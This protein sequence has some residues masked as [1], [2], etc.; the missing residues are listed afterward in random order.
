[1]NRRDYYFKQRVM[2]DELDAG[3]TGAEAAD[4]DLAVDSG[5]VGVMYGLN[6]AQ[7][8]VP[9]LTVLV[10]QGTAYDSQGQR[11]HVDNEQSV[12]CSIDHLGVNTAVVNA[13][14]RKIVSIF[15]EFERSLSDPRTDGNGANVYFQRDEGFI[16]WVKQGAESNYPP[17]PTPPTLESGAILLCDITL[18]FGQATIQ[19]ADISMARTQLQ[20]MLNGTPYSINARTAREAFTQVLALINDVVVGVIT[21]D[22]SQIDYA[23]G[24]AWSD[25]ETNPA[26]SVE[27]QLDKI[28]TD[29]TSTT[30]DHSGAH[31]LGCAA[32]TAWINGRT[33]VA[34][35]V[36]A[37]I[38]KIITD[39]SARDAADDGAERIG[40][41]AHAGSPYALAEG[42]VRSQINNLAD[43]INGH[44]SRG[45]AD[46]HIVAEDGMATDGTQN[47]ILA[48]D[49]TGWRD[50]AHL[51]CTLGAL[52]NGDV[53]HAECSG[54]FDPSAAAMSYRWAYKKDGGAATQ[55]PG[56]SQVAGLADGYYT[57]LAR[58][59]ITSNG[60]Y[61]FLLQGIKVG[62]ADTLDVNYPT[63]RAVAIR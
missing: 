2:E 43:A 48:G 38:D 24:G 1:M 47:E 50:L 36:Y 37:A 20:F 39:L 13:G 11:S 3:F 35:T 55:I 49:A 8:A 28:V 5:L 45:D 52:L 34:A 56:T 30:A 42:S 51:T 31:R 21:L 40:T 6:V 33:N 10:G 62:G 14:Y 44:A 22:A 17:A 29:L 18:T 25:G 57:F 19:N 46:K 12:D 16:L 54:Y 58:Y 59:P 63:A 53:V 60:S 27:A 9:D 26:A 32:R 4:H 61:V 23:G 15:L 41:E 7:N